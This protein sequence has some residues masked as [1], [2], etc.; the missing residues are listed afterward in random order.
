[1]TLA[2]VY[3]DRSTE[4]ECTSLGSAASEV[5][6][7]TTGG[8]GK[9]FYTPATYIGGECEA[10]PDPSCG[11]VATCASTTPVRDEWVM[12]GNNAYASLSIS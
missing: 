5:G 6:S 9:W 7:W 12:Y 2:S 11:P 10:L 1:M 4:A 8:A 3:A